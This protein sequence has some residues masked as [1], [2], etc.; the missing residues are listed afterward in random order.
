MSRLSLVA[1]LGALVLVCT[2][3]RTCAARRCRR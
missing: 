1:A 2:G 3:C